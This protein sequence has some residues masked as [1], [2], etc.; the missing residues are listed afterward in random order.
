MD[1]R[2]LRPDAMERQ[3]VEQ[4]HREI[5]RGIDRIGAVAELSARLHSP[6]LAPSLRDLMAWLESSLEPH[7]AWEETW[8]YPRLERLAGS[9]WLARLMRFEHDQIARAI[10]RLASDEECLRREPTSE[11]LA[12]LRAHLYGLDALIRAH[13]EREEHFLFPILDDPTPAT[14]PVGVVVP[15]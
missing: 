14:P 13:L 11:R 4:E 2:N 15:A 9:P 1:A 12:G 5:A 10:A 7:D 8:L 3:F 6:D